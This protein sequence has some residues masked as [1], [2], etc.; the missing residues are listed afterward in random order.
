LASDIWRVPAS[1]GEERRIIDGVYRYSFAV[2]PQG[3]YFVSAPRFQKASFIG[4]LE[5]DGE[6]V[7]EVFRLPDPADL[8]L[9]LSP[10]YKHLYF[11][12]ADYSD[13]DIMLVEN[14]Q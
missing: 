5:F 9:G 3:L 10:D 14:V 7:S 1:G 11:A 13:S 2:T 4:F 12:K 8:G 6:K